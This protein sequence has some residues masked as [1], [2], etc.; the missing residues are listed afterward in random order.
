LLALTNEILH[1]LLLWQ[2][3][4]VVPQVVIGDSGELLAADLQQQANVAIMKGRVGY[5][6][7]E[8]AIYLRV[9]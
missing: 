8:H 5:E 2:Q 1:R 4:T 9:Q 6:E 3:M 7:E